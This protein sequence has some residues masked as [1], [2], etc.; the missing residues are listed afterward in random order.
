MVEPEERSQSSTHGSDPDAEYFQSVE[1][2]FVSRRGDPLLLSNADWVLIREWRQGGLPLRIVLR[3]IRDA[4]DA[5][6]HSFGRRRKVGSLRYCEH[7]VEAARERWYRAL[8]LGRDAATD[9]GGLL[10]RLAARLVAAD[11][12]L[13]VAAACGTVAAELR[14]RAAAVE[15]PAALDAWLRESEARLVEALRAA[16]EDGVIAAL[17]AQIDQDLAPYRERMPAHVLAQVRSES[18]ARRL[19][20]R[21]GLPR[22]SLFDAG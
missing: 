2:F 21:H 9:L 11:V 6:A 14:A 22:M 17:E 10:T 8:S 1:E 20:E 15:D 4:F 12:P 16:E 18:L 3:G 19:L 13:A 7:E 5:H